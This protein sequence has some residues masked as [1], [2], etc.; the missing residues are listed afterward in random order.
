VTR[1]VAVAL[2]GALAAFL[3]IAATSVAAASPVGITE[4][5]GAAFPKRVYV[6]SLPSAERIQPSSVTVTENGHSV[7]DQTVTPAAGTAGGKTSATVLAI[8]ASD[9]MT[10]AAIAGA[11]EAARAFAARRNVNQSL[12]VLTFNDQTKVVLPL[13]KSQGQIVQALE[14]QPQLAFGTHLY[15]AVAQGVAALRTAGVTAGSLIVLSDGANLGSS[16]SLDQAIESAKN[17]HVRVFTVG[18]KSKTLRPTSLQRFAAETGGSFSLASSPAD[19]SRIYDQ[20]GLQLA[21]EYL[22]SYNSTV[23]PGRP[24][25]VAVSVAG[26]GKAN[27]GYVAPV[28]PIPN[29]VYHPSA[30]DRVTQSW[31]TMLAVGLLLPLLVALAIVFSTRRRS[32][33]RSRV[34]DYVSMPSRKKETD[35]IVSRVFIGAERSL[36]RTAWWTKFKNAVEF[37]EIPIKPVYIVFGTVVLTLFAAWLLYLITPVLAVAAIL[38]PFGVRAIITSRIARKRRLFADQL[39]DNLDVLAS[40]LRAG[41][42]LIGSFAVVVND[43]PEPSRSEFQRVVADEQLGVLL[44]DA[45]STLGKRMKSRD[46]EQVALVAS[47]QNETGANAAEVLD[48]VT[49]SIRERQELRRLVQ[50]LTA[51]GRFARW[52]VTALP[53]VLLIGITLLNRDYMKPLFTHTLGLVAVSIAG[54]MIIAGSVVI[55]RIVDI[56]V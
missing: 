31:V 23:R 40:G 7:V 12:G 50:T 30:L 2:A 5:G 17:A 3:A 43:A 34:S 38:V 4:A 44:E 1:R 42:S 51:Q 27:A 48:R 46:V 24:V 15:D 13:T 36:E 16:I 33:V 35:A 55:G 21:H 14:K 11:V 28:I 56:E 26:V 25:K 53:I 41:H 8:D 32:T 37:A 9:S 39:P 18:L 52:I 54:V 22:L 20:L 49:E 10:G 19:L 6:L 45:L 47:V 29:A